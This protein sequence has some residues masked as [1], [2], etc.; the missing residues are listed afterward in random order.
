MVG[1]PEVDIP[2]GLGTQVASTVDLLNR[3]LAHNHHP[4]VPIIPHPFFSPPRINK[5]ARPRA[6]KPARALIRPLS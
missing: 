2:A 4:E 1:H 5:I 3:H 6:A